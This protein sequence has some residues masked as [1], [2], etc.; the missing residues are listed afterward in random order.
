[1]LLIVVCYKML[2]LRLKS[3]KNSLLELLGNCFS[4]IATSLVITTQFLFCFGKLRALLEQSNY[5]QIYKGHPP[6]LHQYSLL[7]PPIFAHKPILLRSTNS[8][9]PHLST[10]ISI[11]ISKYIL[12]RPNTTTKDCNSSPTKCSIK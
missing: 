5:I 12:H 2:C 8:P 3:D 11:Y 6:G 7:N 1:M 4:Y 9:I 10:N